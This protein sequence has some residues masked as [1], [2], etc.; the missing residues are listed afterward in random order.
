LAE[1]EETP[2]NTDAPKLATDGDIHMKF[3]SYKM[4]SPNLGPEKQND[5]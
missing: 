2:E 1:A 3:S 4:C 5:V